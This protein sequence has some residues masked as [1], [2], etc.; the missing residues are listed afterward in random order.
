MHARALARAYTHTCT[1]SQG[2]VYDL[3]GAPRHD[4][5]ALHMGHEIGAPVL[6]SQ[7]PYIRSTPRQRQSHDALRAGK[8]GPPRVGV[9]D[10]SED[11]GFQRSRRGTRA[12]HE[13]QRDVD[14]FA[15]GLKR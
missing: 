12:T 9:V 10:A 4:S 2:N 7:K 14:I 11:W 1:L 8:S 13:S 5:H 15:A 6:G 3:D